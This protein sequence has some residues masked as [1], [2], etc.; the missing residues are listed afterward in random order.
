MGQNSEMRKMTL[1]L[2]REEIGGD[3]IPHYYYRLKLESDEG[4]T[5]IIIKFSTQRSQNLARQK[6]LLSFP[7]LQSNI[8]SCFES[9]TFIYDI[10]LYLLTFKSKGS[11]M[12]NWIKI[13]KQFTYNSG[14]I[15]NEFEIEES[16]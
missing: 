12:Y 9:K 5:P 1:H 2:L 14:I 15:D 13:L 10:K 8:K 7:N 11:N 6:T 16:D 3:M 4:P